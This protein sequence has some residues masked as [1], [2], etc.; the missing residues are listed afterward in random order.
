MRFK[1][2]INNNGLDNEL[3]HVDL[4][5]SEPERNDINKDIIPIKERIKF[6]PSSIDTRL[7]YEELAICCLYFII[8]SIS[9]LS[10]DFLS[11]INPLLMFAIIILLSSNP[12]KVENNR[13]IEVG[14][15]NLI[16]SFNILIKGLNLSKIS[17]NY[18]DIINLFTKLF[19]Y[20]L[21]LAGHPG[22]N[23]LFI[24]IV[25][26][27]AFSYLLC[28]INK[29]MDKIKESTSYI[30]SKELAFIV[31]S[32]LIFALNFKG[33]VSNGTIFATVILLKYFQN[34]IKD[35]EIKDINQNKKDF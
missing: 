13:A 10:K 32:T 17:N 15:W 20:S 21:L 6:N 25:V 14:T 23:S 31:I 34:I 12:I 1:N 8:C 9:I 33:S 28:F 24:I 26:G 30:Q 5:N 27:L 16:S 35:I 2:M 3:R 22:F 18:E 29:D 11:L 19:T 7:Y 4:N